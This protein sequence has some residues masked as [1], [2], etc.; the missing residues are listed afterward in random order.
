[1]NARAVRG[2]GT[3]LV[4]FVLV[5]AG[6]LSLVA[7]FDAAGY[8][9]VE[10]PS[11]PTNSLAYVGAILVVT[12]LMLAAFKYDFERAVR[13]VIVLSSALLS[14]YVFSVVGPGGRRSS[15][16]ARPASPS[17]SSSTPSGTSSTPR[18]C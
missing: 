5:Q 12:A 15:S 6:A 16:P 17:P 2:V 10:N 14:W 18:A 13:A 8:R 3:A 11:D 7:P 1:V 4:V 9:A